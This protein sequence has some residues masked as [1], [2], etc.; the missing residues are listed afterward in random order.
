MEAFNFKGNPIVP[1]KGTPIV[2]L[3]AL[4]APEV[5]ALIR[6]FEIGHQSSG[7]RQGLGFVWVHLGLQVCS[8]GGSGFVAVFLS[9]RAGLGFCA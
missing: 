6:H 7:D 9:L 8:L 2:P 1:L 3:G 5:V 4:P